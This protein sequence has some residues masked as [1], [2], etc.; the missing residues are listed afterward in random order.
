MV[1]VFTSGRAVR[2]GLGLSGAMIT[3]T[4]SLSS[5]PTGSLPSPFSL[6]CHSSDRQ[7]VTL[8]GT[9]IFSIY[10][11]ERLA[12][13]FDFAVSEQGKYES[14]DPQLL[15]E[16]LS[17]V[18][19]ATILSSTV[20]RSLACLLG[21]Q[22]ELG[23]EVRNQLNLSPVLD[24][25]GMVVESFA[26]TSI[27]PSPEINKALEAIRSEELKKEADAA[28]HNR[29]IAAELKDRQ[30]KEEQLATSRAVQIAEREI[31]EA[32][33]ETAKRKS[34]LE[35]EVQRI[36]LEQAEDRAQAEVT[37][38]K[39]RSLEVS[40]RSKNIIELGEAEGRALAARSAA[41]EGL[42]AKKIQAL[43]LS[44]GKAN[45]T[46]A[47][48]FLELAERAD[49]IGSLNITPDLLQSLMVNEPTRSRRTVGSAQK[50]R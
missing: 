17:E 42:D 9:A 10:K 45:V 1:T 34:S 13:A 20:R 6:A 14:E 21:P 47:A 41:L 44:G 37:V 48:A 50:E 8:A 46:I 16:R 35:R 39:I 49:H 31:L 5:V 27:E 38:S 2:S 28:I 25:M 12:K 26:I 29:Q 15:H 7:Q 23:A 36:E 32:Q 22:E 40:E 3:T 4:T 24:R 43:A 18:L 19:S 33:Y 11:P 30:L